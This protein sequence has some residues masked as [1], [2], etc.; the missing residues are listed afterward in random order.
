M[1]F[2]ILAFIKKLISM[3]KINIELLSLLGLVAVNIKI[4]LLAHWYN[5]RPVLNMRKRKSFRL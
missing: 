5:F 3:L 1:K 2:K 4:I